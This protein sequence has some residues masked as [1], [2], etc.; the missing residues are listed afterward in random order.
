ME[1]L[2]AEAGSITVQ[3]CD[4]LEWLV[5]PLIRTKV[6][7]ITA[8]KFDTLLVNAPRKLKMKGDKHDTILWAK[9]YLSLKTGRSKNGMMI[10]LGV[11]SI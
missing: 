2:E 5:E 4:S 10:M 9:E 7:A 3:M 8:R 6:G 11:L 1:D